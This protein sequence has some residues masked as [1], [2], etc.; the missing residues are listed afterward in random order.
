MKSR[1]ILPL[2]AVAVLV[3]SFLLPQTSEASRRRSRTATNPQ[4]QTEA[5]QQTPT[6]TPAPA[7][8]QQTSTQSTQSNKASTSQP[9]KQTNQ[10]TESA[11]KKTEA[12]AKEASG[13]KGAQTNKKKGGL[14]QIKVSKPDLA[15]VMKISLD[16]NHR[17]YYPK[18]WTKY[19]RNDTTMSPEEF[20]Y[21]YL[22]YM[23]QEDYDPYR[24]SKYADIVDGYR[25]KEKLTKA[26][27]DTVR[28]YATKALEDNPFDLRQMSFLVHV[29][30]MANKPM[31]AKVWEYRLE[32]FLGAIK[33]TGTGEDVQNAW[34]VI[35]PMHEYD[36][37]QMMGYEAVD[38]E[39][40][41]NG[42]FDRLLVQPDGSRKI[43]K[44]VKSFYFNVGVPQQQYE[45]KHI[46]EED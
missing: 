6:N 40:V 12:A 34:F 20:R 3:A 42:K 7:T 19:Q 33:S 27:I 4:T 5:T 39:Y 15:E 24:E 44:P 28:K 41:E 21:L 18:L 9:S 2:L 29:L 16:P 25:D 46:G 38:V 10:K 37:V 17:Y 1:K 31:T 26:E 13:G 22:G 8:T 35:Y 11:T 30:K 14:T 23:F 45:M 43:S 36:M 32:N